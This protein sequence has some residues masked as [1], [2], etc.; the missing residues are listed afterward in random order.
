MGKENQI[1]LLKEGGEEMNAERSK[2]NNVCSSGLYQF[3]RDPMT[4]YY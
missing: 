2:E 3:P 4:K 1:Q